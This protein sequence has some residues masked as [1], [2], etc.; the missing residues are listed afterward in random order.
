MKNRY[1]SLNISSFN[2]RGI[3]D[4][5]KRILIFNWLQKSYPG[6]ILLQE[7]HSVKEDEKQWKKEWEGQI[8]FS[9]GTSNSKG[10]AILISPNL[11]LKFS[12]IIN[13]PDG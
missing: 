8:Y 7:T 1:S 3:R 6:I 5:T 2:C 12:N 4:K 11:D 13:D 10:V 9:H